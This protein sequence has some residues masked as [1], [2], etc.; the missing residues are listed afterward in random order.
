MLAQPSKVI[1]IQKSVGKNKS[2]ASL[3][4]EPALAVAGTDG[5]F[6]ERNVKIVAV[7][8]PVVFPLPIL[9]DVFGNLLNQT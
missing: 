9:F 1:R 6:Q 3:F 8:G 4:A 2:Q 7:L 5:S